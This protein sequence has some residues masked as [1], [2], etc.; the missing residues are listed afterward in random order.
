MFD[1]N[2]DGRIDFNEF[3]LAVAATSQGDLDDRLEIAFDMWVQSSY[4]L[5]AFLSF[6]CDTSNDGQID[7]KEL[8]TM[9]SAMVTF[10][11]FS[12]R[13]FFH[14]DKY[15]NFKYD[16]LGET[17]RK[18]DHDPKTRASE[19]ISR[20]DVDGDKKLNKHEFVAGYVD[21]NTIQRQLTMLYF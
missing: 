4:R 3:I 8:T 19:I 17:N 9:I 21:E 16:L 20:L 2:H 6:R 15:A 10:R 11:Y 13:S 1:A 18:G 12:Y 5:Y 7:R 14:E